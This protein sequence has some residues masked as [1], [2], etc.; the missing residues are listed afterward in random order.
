MNLKGCFSSIKYSVSW[1]I[2]S[3]LLKKK[4]GFYNLQQKLKQAYIPT[5]QK[6]K[7]QKR[8]GK[9]RQL[10]FMLKYNHCYLCL[11]LSNHSNKFPVIFIY[12]YGSNIEQTDLLSLEI[13]SKCHDYLKPGTC[14]TASFPQPHQ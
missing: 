10:N 3:F 7:A 11:R 13:T 9:K 8:K 6:E 5:K 1:S 14:S 4:K 2:R 12:K